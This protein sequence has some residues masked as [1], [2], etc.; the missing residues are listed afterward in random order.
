MAGTS[1][2]SPRVGVEE[3]L[4]GHVDDGQP[5]VDGAHHRGLTPDSKHSLQR[6]APRL[7]EYKMGHTFRP[8]ARHLARGVGVFGF[9]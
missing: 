3:A 5:F 2:K 6:W 9:R 7:A 4:Q 1:A 8:Q